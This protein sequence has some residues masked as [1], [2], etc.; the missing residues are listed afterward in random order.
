[1]MR[2][3]AHE[4]RRAHMLFSPLLHD[5]WSHGDPHLANVLY[6]PI[7]QRAR[8]IDFETRHELTLRACERHA[9]DLLVFLLDLLGADRTS[10]WQQ[11]SSEFLTTYGRGEAL[12]T[13]HHRLNP[14]HGL[15]LVLWKTRTNYL[16][17]ALLLERIAS[18]RDLI[19]THL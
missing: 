12:R 16:P 2:A 18:I 1:M 7:T 6:D 15:E 17:K 5:H 9:D 14:P 19:E 3:A 8:L 11:L 4:F 10:G 13:L